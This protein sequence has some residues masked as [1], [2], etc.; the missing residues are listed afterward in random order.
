MKKPVGQPQTSEQVLLI[1]SDRFLDHVT[2]SGH[3]ERPERAEVMT[4]VA[5]RWAADG[6]VVADPAAIEMQALLRVHDAEYVEAIAAT[7]G[8]TVRLDPDTY[9]SADS[10][11]VAKLAAGAAVVGVEHALANGGRA[12]AFVRPPGHHAERGR[13]MGFCL[14]NNV[15]VAAA[16]ALSRGLRNV[17]IVDYDVHHGN[18]TQWMFYDEPRVLY[19]SLHQYP[20]YPGTGAAEDVGTGPGMGFTFNVPIEAGAG[21]ADYDLVFGSAVV[22]VLEAFSPE[23]VLLSAG[24][25][26]HDRDPLGGMRVST[27]GYARMTRALC[28]V[29]DRC[30][31]GRMVTVTEGGYDL[32]ALEECLADT[33]KVMREPAAP[34]PAPPDGSAHRGSS[35]LAQVRRAQASFWPAL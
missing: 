15:A 28:A 27:S 24:Y 4:S 23:L 29:A 33:L 34:P 8:R 18:G 12:V 7:A 2:P 31:G 19:L 20:F 17:A 10:G 1:T 13:A 32:E 30:C 25:D 11:A 26:A 35:A 6:G 5:Q 22:P 16:H 21:D 14:F 3:P 9:A